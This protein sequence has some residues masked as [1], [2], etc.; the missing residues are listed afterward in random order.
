MTELQALLFDVDGTLADT[1]RDAHRPAFNKTF[2][3]SGLDWEWDVELYGELLRV[4]GGKERMRHYLERYR[5]GEVAPEQVGPLVDALYKVKTRHYTSSLAQGTMPLRPGVLRLIHEARAAGLRL[6][7]VTTTSPD[8]VAALL[9]HSFAPDAESWFEVIAAGDI[10]QAKKPAP[11]IYQW[12]LAQLR[13]EPGQ[14]LALEDSANGVRASLAAGVPT[15]VT[16]NGYTSKESFDGALAVLSDLG[17]PDAP[18]TVIRGDAGGS[19]YVDL[20]L[21]RRWHACLTD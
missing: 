14:C 21:L 10:V 15:V 11:D 2:A 17:E 3:E 12:A 13:L 9:R 18:F 6:A 19:S 5:P 1:E 7:I 16:V 4:T 8:N 20:P